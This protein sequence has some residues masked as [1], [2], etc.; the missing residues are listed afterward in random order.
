MAFVASSDL[1]V[2]LNLVLAVHVEEDL[3][4]LNTSLH[5]FESHL[6]NGSYDIFVRKNIYAVDDVVYNQYQV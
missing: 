1:K 4:D 3:P 2:T 5:V 6:M